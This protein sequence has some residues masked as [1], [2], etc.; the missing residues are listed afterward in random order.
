MEKD[1]RKKQYLI[2]HGYTIV[3]FNETDLTEPEKLKAKIIKIMGYPMERFI[4]KNPS[5]PKN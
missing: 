1:K 5:G 3:Y 2:D 4:E